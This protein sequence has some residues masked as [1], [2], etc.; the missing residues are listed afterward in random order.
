[1]RDV[2]TRRQS[3]G[4]LRDETLSPGISTG[5]ELAQEPNAV[6]LDA[7]I[8]VLAHKT[9]VP[10][11]TINGQF[12]ESDF[13]AALADVFVGQPVAVREVVTELELI[14]AGLVEPNKSASVM[15][16]TGMAGVGKTELAKRVTELYSSSPR[17]QVYSMGIFTETHSVSGII[18]VPSGYVGHDE[19]DRLINELR[20]NPCAVF[21][22]DEAEKCHPNA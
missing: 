19:G 14:S 15:M 9:G 12:R 17:L 7:V 3:V 4:D 22:L 13:E 20:A 11:E 16:L 21:L 6:A 8:G 2:L 1:M 10:R 18:G 5:I